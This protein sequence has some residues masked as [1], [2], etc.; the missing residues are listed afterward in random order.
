MLQGRWVLLLFPIVMV[1]QQALIA[2]F[3]MPDVLPS[4]LMDSNVNLNSKQHKSKE[5]GHAPWFAAFWG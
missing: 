1:L 5:S 3:T 4:S 2:K